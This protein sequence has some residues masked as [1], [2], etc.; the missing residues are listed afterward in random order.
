MSGFLQREGTDEK[1]PYARDRREE[2]KG[3]FR[4]FVRN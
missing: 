1:C 2:H 3:N 4:C